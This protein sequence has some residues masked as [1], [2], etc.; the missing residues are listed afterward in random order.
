MTKQI[1]VA[2]KNAGKAKEFEA[3]FAPHGIKVLSLLDL[4]NSPDI[5]ETGTTFEENAILKAEGIANLSQSV[6]IADDSGLIIDELDGMPGIFSARYAGEDKDD[7]ANIDKVLFE[8]KDVPMEKRTGRFYCALAFAIPRV[9]TEVVAG[10]CEGKI[11][12]ERQGLDGFGY[13]PIFYVDKEG[14]SMAEMLPEEKNKISH[15][16]LALKKLEP[17]VVQYFN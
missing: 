5:E 11:L 6:V 7:D 14:K 16:S 13:D 12:N 17:L 2:T 15:R 10:V 9:K 4:A 8:M 1:I 3:L